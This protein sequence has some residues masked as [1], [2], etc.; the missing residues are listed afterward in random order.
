MLVLAGAGSGK[1]SV[2]TAKIAHLIQRCDYKASHIAAVTFT[3]KAAREMRTRV[4]QLLGKKTTKGLSVSTFHRLGLNIIRREYQHLNFKQHFT[5]FDDQDTSSLLKELGHLDNAG[6][7]LELSQ[8]QQKISHWKNQFITPDQAIAQAINQEDLTA[9]KLF[10]AYDRNMRAYNAVDFDDLIRYPVALLQEYKALREKWQNKIRYLLVDEYQD[11]NSCQYELIKL[12]CGTQGMMTVV[13]DDDQS[14]YSWR[15]A[16][17]ENLKQLKMDYPNLNIIKLEQNYRSCGRILHTANILIQ[18]ND[19]LFEKKLWSQKEYGEPIRVLVAENDNDEANRVVTEILAHQLRAGTRFQ[20]YAILYRGNHQSKFLEKI[21]VEKQVPYKVSGSTSFF[22]RS[23]IKDIMAYLRLLINLD[24]DN[25]FLRIVNRPKREIGPTTLEKLGAYAQE[26]HISLFSACFEL[27]LE[28]HLSGKGLAAIKRFAK[29]ITIASDNLQRGNSFAVIQDL[30][31]S[32]DYQTWLYEQ[33]SSP[34]AAEFKWGNVQQLLSWIEQ[35]ID[36]NQQE[37]NPVA[38]T[39]NRLQLREMIENNEEEEQDNQVQ[40]MT[41]HASKGLEFPHVYLV[42]MEEELLPHL[43]S[44]EEENIEEE[45][46]LA[47]VGVTRAQ[48]T[49]TLTYAQQRKRYG[50]LHNT[51]PSRFLMELPKDDLI[52]EGQNTTEIS[53]EQIRE[54]GREQLD[55][56]RKMLI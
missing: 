51:E 32:I 25:A 28:Q 20:D 24:D 53:E 14:I 1:T 2:I 21:L 10:A 16:Q 54:K 7:K 50:H 52:W 19:H 5:I 49:L 41:L 9:A 43:T 6:D 42:G 33:A 17:P 29:M 46:R 48:Q 36:N 13:G 44:I 39:I 38:V 27:G 23:E 34:V 26:R 55:K 56:L 8:H 3:N 31:Q 22:A 11:T 35:G 4:D 47:Y 40:L 45:R 12:I 15:G 37:D 18:N 30:I